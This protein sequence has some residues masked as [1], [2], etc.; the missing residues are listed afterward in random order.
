MFKLILLCM[1]LLIAGCHMSDQEALA[2]IK[3]CKSIGYEARTYISG[4]DY[5]LSDITCN[6]D[7]PIIDNKLYESLYI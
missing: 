1:V 2:K 7:K 6:F 4:L 5:K 3:Y